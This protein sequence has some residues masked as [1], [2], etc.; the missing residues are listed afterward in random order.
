K[1]GQSVVVHTNY[2]LLMPAYIPISFVIFN[3]SRQTKPIVLIG[4]IY[5]AG[6][7]QVRDTIK[8][9]RPAKKTVYINT[10]FNGMTDG[11]QT[12][13]VLKLKMSSQATI[14]LLSQKATLR[15]IVEPLRM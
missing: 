3:P 1:D 2:P 12:L 13:Q 14:H 10:V 4:G 9:N 6:Q 8:A 7:K 15:V 11:K 5:S